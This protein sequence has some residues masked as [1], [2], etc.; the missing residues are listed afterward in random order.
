[1]IDLSGRQLANELCLLAMDAGFRVDRQVL[2]ADL[3]RCPL[4]QGL[5]VEQMATVLVEAAYGGAGGGAHTE[6]LKAHHLVH[7][8][9]TILAPDLAPARLHEAL[10]II[11]GSGASEAGLLSEAEAGAFAVMLTDAFVKD[12][13]SEMRALQAVLYPVTALGRETPVMAD[14]DLHAFLLDARDGHNAVAD[15]LSNLMM[16]WTIQRALGNIGRRQAHT[17]VVVG[18][19][20]L[21]PRHLQHLSD[22]CADRPDT[23]LVYLFRHLS[24]SRLQLLGG[25]GAVGFMR[26][27][28]PQQAEA[29]AAYI[30]KDYRFT[31][32]SKTLTTGGSQTHGTS[33]TQTWGES[34]S[35]G[36]STGHGRA[37]SGTWQANRFLAKPKRRA[38][39]TTYGR[40][41]NLGTSEGTS[42]G[43]SD[44][45]GVSWSTSET[46]Q[47]VHEFAVEPT[48][49]QRMKD[50]ALLLV[51]HA[52]GTRHME[53]LDC[54]PDL[55]L[56]RRTNLTPTDLS[57]AAATRTPAPASTALVLPPQPPYL[58]ALAPTAAPDFP[59]PPTPSAAPA[60][61]SGTRLA[62][63]LAL[64]DRL[65]TT[66]TRT[67]TRL[68]NPPPKHPTRRR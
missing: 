20:H 53:L 17:V 35:E 30:G 56:G 29:A 19:D 13:M 47:R 52:G 28:N 23:Q 57:H 43:T 16:Q 45:T 63:T 10:E 65:T 54:D 11:M 3:E 59:Y 15:L 1:M 2:P 4:V 41:W 58:T 8:I 44:S 25:A 40:S 5:T 61:G 21:N 38:T 22:L 27:A 33:G 31:I 9:C 37:T 55:A 39:S 60:S 68:W 7:R 66:A 36:G 42:E 64:T 51:A 46:L 32:A 14:A 48:E 62:K 67:L 18:A 49:I 6:R 34:E 26:M 50:Y 12:A 24:E